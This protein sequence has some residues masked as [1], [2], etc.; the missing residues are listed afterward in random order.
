MT[1]AFKEAAAGDQSGQGWKIADPSDAAIRSHWWEV[2]QDP[3]LDE[4]EERVAI[5]NQTIVAAEASYRA[6][7]ALVLEAQAQLFP[8]F[9]LDPRDAR[10]SSA[11]LSGIGG[12]TTAG[13][14]TAAKTVAP[15]RLAHAMSSP[16]RWTRLI[17]SI[18][19]AAFAIPWP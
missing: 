16:C 6:A 10:K 11:A 8:T 15:G 13:T 4:L 5:S 7:H 19:G 17:R 12:T 18:S 1:A 2:Y 3:Q 9:S 14:G